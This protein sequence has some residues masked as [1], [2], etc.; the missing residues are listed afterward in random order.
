VE[1]ARSYFQGTTGE[2]PLDG[3][4]N[5]THKAV[6]EPQLAVIISPPRKDGPIQEQRQ[7]VRVTDSHLNNL[8]TCSTHKSQKRDL[9]TDQLR[10]KRDLLTLTYLSCMQ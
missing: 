6:G 1:G 5:W 9:E 3:C 7:I 4:R 2:E 8:T 10:S